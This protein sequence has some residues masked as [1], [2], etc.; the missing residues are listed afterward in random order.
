M[1]NQPSSPAQCDD[2]AGSSLIQTTIH[3]QTLRQIHAAAHKT[4]QTN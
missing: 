4:Q 2:V 1:K 3:L